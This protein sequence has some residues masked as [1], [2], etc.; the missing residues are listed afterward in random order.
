[1]LGKKISISF[2]KVLILKVA[3]QVGN[4]LGTVGLLYQ[5]HGFCGV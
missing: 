2:R 5:K 4:F 3:T 1:M